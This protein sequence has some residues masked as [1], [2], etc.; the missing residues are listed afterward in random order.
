M[1]IA[2]LTGLGAGVLSAFLL[3]AGVTGMVAQGGLLYNMPLIIYLA[4]VYFSIKR[5]STVEHQGKIEFKQA[6]KAGGITAIIICL[7]V[8]FGFYIALTH[9]DVRGQV[10]NMFDV[11]M[12]KEEIMLRLSNMNN[13]KMFQIARDFSLIYFL[14][15]FP[16]IIGSTV[17]IRVFGRRKSA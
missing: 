2:L 10:Q 16:F 5:T 11:Q 12:S 13:P 15:G 8:W 14:L 1:R 4:A 9:T 7:G 3:F 6:L 17:V